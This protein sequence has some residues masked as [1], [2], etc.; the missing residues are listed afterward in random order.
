MGEVARIANAVQIAA[1]DFADQRPF[2]PAMTSPTLGDNASTLPSLQDRI[3]QERHNLFMA[4][5]GSRMLVSAPVALAVLLP[6]QQAVSLGHTTLWA[7]YILAITAV[8]LLT[9][10]Y[11]NRHRQRESQ[12]IRKWHAINMTMALMWSSLWCMAPFLFFS[13]ADTEQLL[14]FLLII[15]LIS[16]MPSVSMGVYPDIF[17]SF[18]SPIFLS[19][20]AYLSYFHIEQ[21]WFIKI[22]PLFTLASL[23][24]FSLYIH[25][26]QL[27]NI[28]LRIEAEL[29]R[30]DAERANRSKNR[31]LAAISHDLRQPMQA[32]TLYTSLIRDQGDI[33]S[34]AL[35][36]KLLS[37]LQSGSELLDQLLM[38]SRLQSGTLSAQPR[39][40]DLAPGLQTLL[41]ECRPLAREKGLTI[42]NTV[43]ASCEVFAD[44][45]L[46]SQILRNLL[47]NAIKYTEQGSISVSSQRDGEQM[48][49]SVS[50]TGPGIEPQFHDEIFDEFMQ[51]DNPHRSLQNGVG[52]GL[53]IVRHLCNLS[54]TPLTLS[55]QPGK[56]SSFSI[57][58]PRA[59]KVEKLQTAASD[60]LP[61][62]CSLRVVLVDDDPRIT[63]SL[64][65]VLVEW[66]VDVYA[67]NRL[68][69]AQAELAALSV[70]TPDLLISDG[71]LAD[72]HTANEVFQRLGALYATAIPT[73][74]LSGMSN[75]DAVI[76]ADAT[77]LK[78]VSAEALKRQILALCPP[79]DG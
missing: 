21:P 9:V 16:S 2:I 17:I 51:L 63:A 6:F 48:I 41:D 25:K 64:S 11:Y 52:L 28:R 32:A 53:S 78:P 77:L 43:G 4:E 50:D 36:Q 35:S 61:A 38:L 20:T 55:S 31:F 42:H 56:G 46:V 29:A 7:G 18:I 68:D 39:H 23:S 27:N 34:Q 74:L 5:V 14:V 49:L 47:S 12:K 71:Q 75:A 30:R 40:I 26:A 72:G 45:L 58:L 69:E 66:G 37:A 73:L 79:A 1:Q 57:S 13:G 70:M 44:P 19:L 62:E 59:H 67:Y 24:L 33:H 60:T 54:G 15:T 65:E 10:T 8:S 76:Q 22:I 3:T